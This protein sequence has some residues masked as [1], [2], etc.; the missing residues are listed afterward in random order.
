MNE[1]IRCDGTVESLQGRDSVKDTPGDCIR[2]QTPGGEGLVYRI[3]L[4]N[5]E[6]GD[7]SQPI[8]CCMV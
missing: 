7:L 5:N 6:L 3:N 2:I 1:V 8:S 4:T